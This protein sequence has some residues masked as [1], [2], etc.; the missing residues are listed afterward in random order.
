MKGGYVSMRHNALRDLNADFQREVCRDVVIEPRLLP[1]EYN[2]EI[3]GTTADRAAPDIS[4]RGIWS[5]FER[6]FFDVCVIHPNA[7]SYK[8]TTPT[9]LYRTHEKEKK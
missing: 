2:M 8:D 9:A 3:N 4:S 6:T 7:P 1:I 5:T